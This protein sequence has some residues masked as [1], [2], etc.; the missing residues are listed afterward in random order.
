MMWCI[1]NKSSATDAPITVL[2]G[3]K[4]IYMSTHKYMVVE[5][6][7]LSYLFDEIDKTLRSY[8]TLIQ[9][10]KVDKDTRSVIVKRWIYLKNRVRSQ[11]P[12]ANALTLLN[13]QQALYRAMDIAY[14]RLEICGV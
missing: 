5:P 13:E 7:P 9:C 10:Q 8:E 14:K 2:D 3:E 11:Q 12:D 6:A 1:C 4:R